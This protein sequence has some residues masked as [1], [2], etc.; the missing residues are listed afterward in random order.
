MKFIPARSSGA[1]PGQLQHLAHWCSLKAS[2]K[3]DCS[4]MTEWVSVPWF[5]GLL[6][7]PDILTDHWFHSFPKL[8]TFQCPSP[9]KPVF[10]RFRRSCSKEIHILEASH[11][12]GNSGCNVCGAYAGFGATW[13]PTSSFVWIQPTVAARLRRATPELR[14]KISSALE[15]VGFCQIWLP[16][17]FEIQDSFHMGGCLFCCFFSRQFLDFFG[18]PVSLIFLLLCFSGFCFSCFFAFLLL[19]FPC[20]SAFV[21]L[22]L[23]TS[24]IL[25]FLFF[26]HVFLLLHFLLL[27]FFASCLYC[28]FVFH[29]LCF[30]LFCLYP[31][32]N[33][34]ETLGETQRNP[35]EI[36]IRN[37]TLPYMKP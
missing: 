18:V 7:D 12:R 17:R 5:V 33:P 14:L 27:C 19:C 32:W 10:A 11:G 24:T 20:F 2:N 9:Q 13:S 6:F 22:C 37:P 16:K 3:L 15:C 35:K 31:K 4:L 1:K 8:I 28:L 26:S 34:R 36:L 25:L 23:S 30:I 21:L 29:F